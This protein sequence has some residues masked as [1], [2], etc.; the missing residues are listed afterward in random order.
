MKLTVNNPNLSLIMPVGCN[1]K[2]SFCYWESG[3]G[4]TLE[5]F[6]FI[7]NTLPPVF[8]QISITGGEPTLS[9]DLFNYLKTARNRFD[10]VVLNTNGHHVKKEYID[11]VDYIN[12]SRH[13]YYDKEN[14]DVF[15]TESVPDY[16]ELKEIC[17]S[18]KVTLNCF[19]PSD[20]TDYSFIERYIMIA[21]LLGS[22]VAFR[23]YYSDLDI[24][25][26]DHDDTLIDYHSC[27]ACLHRRHLIHGVHTTFKYQVQETCEQMD[28]IY[29]LI[30]QPNGDLTFDWAGKN[31]LEYKEV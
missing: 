9:P 19:L 2:C 8:K 17:K 22:R 10:K 4:L 31:K 7:C 29:E 21:K 3:H 23:K 27:G 14:Y 16:E 6:S 12:I 11:L 15:N 13:H 26:V 28:G 20:F 18:G 25:P 5:R 24:L 1:A 30:I